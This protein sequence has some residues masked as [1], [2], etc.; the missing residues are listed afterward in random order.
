[1]NKPWLKKAEAKPSTR[2]RLSRAAQSSDED[3]SDKEDYQESTFQEDYA[4]GK[5]VEADLEDYHKVTLPRRRLARWCNEPYFTDAVRDCY[6]KL[7]IGV[8][9]EGK[10][11]YRLCKIVGVK[12]DKQY[13]LPRVKTEKPVS[14]IVVL[15]VAP[16]TNCYS[17]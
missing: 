2:S 1:M 11:C 6:V 8:N 3:E 7:F 9:E 4:S 14:L 5:V 15:H 12:S 10:R 17:H 16:Q 13:D